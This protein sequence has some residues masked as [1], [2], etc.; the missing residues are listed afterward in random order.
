MNRRILLVDGNN[1][2][3]R[4]FFAM[5]ELA[6][7][8][9]IRT[10]AILGF[11]KGLSWVRYKTKVPLFQTVVLWDGGHAEFRKKL[12]PDYKAGRSMQKEDREDYYRQMDVI[13]QLLKVSGCRQIKVDGVEAD[14]LISIFGEFLRKQGDSSIIYSADGDFHQLASRSCQIFDPHASLLGP[15]DFQKKWG[16]PIEKILL[17]KCL[18]GD[19][20]DNIK[21]VPK[22]GDKRANIVCAYLGIQHNLPSS[23]SG[24][25]PHHTW[26][27]TKEKLGWSEAD[28]KWIE[29]AL[30]NKLLINRNIR[31]MRLPLRWERTHYTE[32]QALDALN[33]WLHKPLK[34]RRKFIE[35]LGRYEMDSIL[36][37]LSSW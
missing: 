4:S 33:Q 24:K 8:D 9:E 19:S 23:K 7:T 12:Y 15:P 10:G 11:I 37:D 16:V 13:R 26:R 14:D 20:S 36:E 1:L 28:G 21:G 27:V 34:N 25:D 22:I 2:A 5:P 30:E 18:V 31:L 6:T 35:L 17:K 32:D 3:A 29:L